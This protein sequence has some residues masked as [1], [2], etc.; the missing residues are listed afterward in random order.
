MMFS[1][2]LTFIFRMEEEEERT[3]RR[4]ERGGTRKKFKETHQEDHPSIL[5][6]QKDDKSN[7]AAKGK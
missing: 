2:E 7:G 1:F 5:Q 6:I 3:G 4:K